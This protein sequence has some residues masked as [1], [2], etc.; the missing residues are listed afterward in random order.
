MQY[1][2]DNKLTG[3]FFIN[4]EGIKK[5]SVQII[6]YG[7]DIVD[8][9]NKEISWIERYK[10]YIGDYGTQHGYN[11]TRGGDIPFVGRDHPLYKEIIPSKLRKLIS[12]GNNAREIAEEV[13]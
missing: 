7:S 4:G 13:N 3:G 9:C 8:L 2:Y 1:I 12:A 5:F 10:S 6:D 11:Q